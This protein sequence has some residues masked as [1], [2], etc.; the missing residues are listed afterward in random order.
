MSAARKRGLVRL[1]ILVASIGGLILIAKGGGSGGSHAPSAPAPSPSLRATTSTLRLPRPLH[2]EAIAPSSGGLLVIGG[3]DRSDTSTDEVLRLDSQA[4]RMSSS[5]T[6]VEPLHD[7]AAATVSGST[8]VFGGGASTTFDTVQ[9]LVP[10]TAARPIGLMPSPVS[11][12]SAVSVGDAA[13]V[14]GG[15]DGRRPVASVLRTTDGHSFTEVAR[16]PTPVRYTTVAASGDKIYAFGGEIGTGVDTNEIQEYDIATGR[17]QV[18][19][20]LSAPVS[21]ASSMVL[22]GVIYLLGGRRGGAA[23]D[24]ILRF[25]PARNTTVPAGR[26]PEPVFDGAAGTASNTGYLVGGIN[27]RD[28]S[29]DSVVSIA[30]R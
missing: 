6:L 8:L 16:L 27:A 13:Y 3:A 11:D 28:T 25:D 2:G 15:Y 24:V 4:R 22:D 9:E 17:A 5:G 7:A 1:A 21:H 26:L 12:L 18:A 29:V 10:G 20:H 23:S 19:G 14:I 30:G